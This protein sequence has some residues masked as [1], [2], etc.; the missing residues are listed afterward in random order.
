MRNFTLKRG[1][2][3]ILRLMLDGEVNGPEYHGELVT[4]GQKWYVGTK[5]VDATAARELVSSGLV[6][7]NF[8]DPRYT[9]YKLTAAAQRTLEQKRRDPDA[10]GNVVGSN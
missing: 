3:R 5:M 4:D 7:E 8:T 2:T 10:A 9:G 6:Q 1:A